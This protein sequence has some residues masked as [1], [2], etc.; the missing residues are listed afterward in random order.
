MSASENSWATYFLSGVTVLASNCLPLSKPVYQ[1]AMLARHNSTRGA[2]LQIDAET[3]A[4]EV[5]AAPLSGWVDN[6]RK[7][8]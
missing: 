4:Q 2:H 7:L 1:A 6:I 3:I 8:L 5:L